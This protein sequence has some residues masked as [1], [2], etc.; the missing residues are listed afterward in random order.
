MV[1]VHTPVTSTTTCT[2]ALADTHTPEPFV[3]TTAENTFAAEPGNATIQGVPP[4]APMP[5][6]PAL[7]PNTVTDTVTAFAPAGVPS[8]DGDSDRV[9]PATSRGPVRVSSTRREAI[10]STPTP[11]AA[12]YAVTA[13]RT[14]TAVVEVTHSAPD[15]AAQRSSWHSAGRG[16]RRVWRH[17]WDLRCT[18]C[19]VRCPLLVTLR[20]TTRTSTPPVAGATPASVPT[21]TVVALPATSRRPTAESSA[22]TGVMNCH[23]LPFATGRQGRGGRRRRLVVGAVVTVG[24]T[25]VTVGLAVVAVGLAVVVGGFVVV[26]TGASSSW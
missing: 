6:L 10:G 3:R 9:P 2:S 12:W 20:A 14:S 5:R 19:S 15:T 22:M 24:L 23:L 26:V 18:A 25:V 13:I 4:H 16:R 1:P 21:C 8:A 11:S 7:A 17:R